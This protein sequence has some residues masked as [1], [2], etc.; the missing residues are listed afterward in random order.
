MHP[1]IRFLSQHPLLRS[2]PWAGE[3][4]LWLQ[5]GW[6]RLT[7]NMA[8]WLASAPSVIGLEKPF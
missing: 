5:R 4:K 7:G 3:A 1:T 6:G 2:R 8:A